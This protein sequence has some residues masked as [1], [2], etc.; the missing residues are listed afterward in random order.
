MIRSHGTKRKMHSGTSKAKQLVPVHLDPAPLCNSRPGM[1]DFVQVTG[2]CKGPIQQHV[3]ILLI[4]F[5]KKP[6]ARD[7]DLS[8]HFLLP[9]VVTA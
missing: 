5:V 9:R 7:Y 3:L 2:P 8:P 1:C 6:T 4:L